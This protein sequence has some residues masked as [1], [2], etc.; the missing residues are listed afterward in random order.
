[1]IVGLHEASFVVWLGATSL[2]VVMRVVRLPPILRQPPAGAAL[3][4][5]LVGAALAAGLTLGTLT[6]PAADHLQDDRSG[7]VGIDAR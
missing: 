3:R 5:G 2:H 7:S 6:F 1:V 4:L